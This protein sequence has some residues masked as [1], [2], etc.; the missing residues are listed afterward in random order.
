MTSVSIWSFTLTK[1]QNAI[2]SEW[3]SLLNI[4]RFIQTRPISIFKQTNPQKIIGP[5]DILASGVIRIL[6]FL[7]L[8]LQACLV[9]HPKWNVPSHSFKVFVKTL[10]ILLL[11]IL[12][13]LHSLF[14]MGDAQFS[15]IFVF[16]LLLSSWGIKTEE[17]KA[18]H[19]C[20]WISGKNP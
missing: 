13:G 15:V 19:K 2:S 7:I 4:L 5:T 16:I 3:Q 6:F 20:L 12:S 18:K 8:K 14:T 11:N 10:K 9:Q 1:I 17:L